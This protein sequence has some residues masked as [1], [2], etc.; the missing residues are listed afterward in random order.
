MPCFEQS[1][2]LDLPDILMYDVLNW[3]LH[4]SWME[5]MESPMAKLVDLELT[6]YWFNLYRVIY[7]EQIFLTSKVS[8]TDQKFDSEKRHHGIYQV[9][10]I[11]CVRA[12]VDPS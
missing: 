8:F 6:Y 7:E 1:L 2:I 5:L 10:V 3:T 9:S 4:V 12:C 11:V